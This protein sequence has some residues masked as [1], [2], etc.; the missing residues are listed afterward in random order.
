VFFFGISVNNYAF[1]A[2]QQAAGRAS[3]LGTRAPP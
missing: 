2:A 3:S 1:I